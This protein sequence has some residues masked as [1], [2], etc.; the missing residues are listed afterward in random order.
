MSSPCI[1][2]G[3]RHAESSNDGSG[4]DAFHRGCRGSAL[5][6]PGHRRAGAAAAQPQAQRYLRGVRQ[7]RRLRGQR[8]WPGRAVRLRHPLPVAPRALDRG[9]P[10]AAAALCRQRR[11]P[12]RLR[13]PHQPRHLRRRQDRPAQGHR[14]HLAHHLL[15]RG[16]AARARGP[17]E[18]R[19]RARQLLSDHHVRQRLRRHL[20]G[21]RHRAQAPRT[22]LERGCGTGRRP[23]F[24]PGPRRRAAP[25]DAVLRARAHHPAQEHRHLQG[26]ARPAGESHDLRLGREPRPRARDHGIVLPGAHRAQAR[27][28][29]GDPACGVGR[30]L[31][32]D[33]Q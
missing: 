16:L 27:A 25:D 23:A 17:H 24:L 8:G 29:G 30:D 19:R 15:V 22:G 13:R 20:R 33:R 11:Q 12:Q 1:R 2:W 5:L 32:H 6:H 3:R 26:D 7:P 10:A 4:G 31:Q 28:Q 21:A 18:P 9:V 14:A